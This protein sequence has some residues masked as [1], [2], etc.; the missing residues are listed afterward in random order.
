MNKP[1]LL[2]LSHRFPSPPDKGDKIRALNILEHLARRY[3]VFLGCLDGDD[4]GSADLNWAERNG[5]RVYRGAP[6]RTQRVLQTASAMINGAPLTLGYFYSSA[7]E[8]WTAR[9]LTEQKPELIYIYSSAMAQYV[10][11]KARH[12]AITIMDFVDVDSL[13]WKQYA[14]SKHWSI[15]WL[16]DLEARR[17]LEHDR[18]VA[19]ATDAS[20]FV[21]AAE[22]DIF[23][24]LAPSLAQ[25][26]FAVSNG[27]DTELFSPAAGSGLNDPSPGLQKIVFVGV[28][29][30][31]PNVEA[32]Q[33]FASEVFPTVRRK[34]PTA[35]FQ[36]VGSKPV[37]SVTALAKQPGIVVTGSVPD[38]RPYLTHAH[39]VVTPLRIARGIQNKVLE[40]MA[41]GKPIVSS[42]GALE[43]IE[44]TAGEHLLV[45]ERAEDFAAHVLACL[46]GDPGPSSMGRKARE[47]VVG[48]YS[49]PSRLAELDRII[50]GIASHQTLDE[51]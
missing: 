27:V 3:E 2:F 40:G 34:A 10:L 36:I 43:G 12:R 39:V 50:D 41:M 29:D 19:A 33:W 38:V 31:W 16:Y 32:V 5:Y 26:L 23:G 37:A 17:L 45:A 20:L 49:W 9:V 21:S 14:S 13:K 18:K 25:R 11:G 15:S 46:S 6:G 42:P 8:K 51:S 35:V 4:D 48:R 24:D 1:K 30:Y 28:M 22:R 7:L 44:A 47:L